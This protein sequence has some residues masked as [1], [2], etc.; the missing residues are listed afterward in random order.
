MISI[1]LPRAA[2]TALLTLPLLALTALIYL[3]TALPAGSAEYAAAALLWLI[4][5]AAFV[6]MAHTGRTDRW[7]APVFSLYAALFAASYLLGRADVAALPGVNADF[8]CRESLPLCHIAAFYNIVP[9]ALKGTVI[10]PG[11]V[12]G[13]STS[14]VSIM[15]VWLGASLVLG[16]G[17]CSWICFFGGFDD[18][19]SRLLPRAVIQRTPPWLTSLPL[20][21]LIFTFLLSTALMFPVYCIATC[22]F[23][24]VTEIPAGSS[25]GEIVRIAIYTSVFISMVIV[26]PLLLKRRAQCS[27]LC[28]IGA[29][30]GGFSR[31]SPFDIKVDRSVCVDCGA[32]VK[33]CPVL[34]MTPESR[35]AGSPGANCTRCGKCLDNC[36]ASA[37]HYHVKGTPEGSHPEL[38]RILF[39]YPA[40]LI[41]AYFVSSTCVQ[42]TARLLRFLWGLI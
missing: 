26:L 2:N 29:L 36:P 16:R 18:F 27:F 10:W 15:L 40:F 34:A 23:K 28:P 31:V 35:A 19:F 37:I 25:P 8:M 13:I 22:A 39:L 33:A 41:M 7:R 17:W 9:A 6:L 11:V 14:V 32:C 3:R 12:S 42:V 5:N 24:V 4:F 20:A 21:V 1:K 38:A 30:Q